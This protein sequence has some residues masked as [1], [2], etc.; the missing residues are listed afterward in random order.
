MTERNE[1]DQERITSNLNESIQASELVQEE[2]VQKDNLD[3]RMKVVTHG[4]VAGGNALTE[5]NRTSSENRLE[6]RE[7]AQNEQPDIEVAN[8][9]TPALPDPALGGEQRQKPE[10]SRDEE[11]DEEGVGGQGLGWTGLV[12]SILAFFIY[13][14]LLGIAGVAFGFFGYRQGAQRLGLWAMVLGG[15]AVLGAILFSPYFVR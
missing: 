6:R 1:S 3:H 14:I 7:Q 4:V 11:R 9:V 12:L 10:P 5:Q 2:P 15:L 8:E 13:P